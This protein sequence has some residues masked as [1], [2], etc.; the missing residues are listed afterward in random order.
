MRRFFPVF[1]LAFGFLPLILA[2]VVPAA[3]SEDGKL[4]FELNC[5]SCHKNGGNFISPSATL[6]KKALERRGMFS[7]EAIK[8]QVTNG[9]GQMPAFKG[10]LKEKQIDAIAAFVMEKAQKGW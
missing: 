9:R 5:S 3:D 2:G 1:L 10:R 7:L 8:K 6:K 4:L